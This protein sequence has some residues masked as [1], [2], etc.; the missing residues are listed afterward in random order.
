MFAMI[1]NMANSVCAMLSAPEAIPVNPNTVAMISSRVTKFRI[2][3]TVY[4]ARTPPTF[5]CF[6][7]CAKYVRARTDGASDLSHDSV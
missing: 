6:L 5:G 3:Q 1:K 2:G 7:N 4:F